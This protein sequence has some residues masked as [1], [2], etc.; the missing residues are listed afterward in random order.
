MTL[1]VIHK[2]EKE[3]K[4]LE[5]HTEVKSKLIIYKAYNYHVHNDYNLWNWKY[6]QVGV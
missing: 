2:T 3:S 1:E 6:K 5:K 4:S